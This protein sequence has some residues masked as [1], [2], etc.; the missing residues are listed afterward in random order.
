MEVSVNCVAILA[1]NMT[2]IKS[3]LRI[4]SCW[5]PVNMDEDEG[6]VAGGGAEPVHRGGQDIY[7]GS[8]G[9]STRTQW[10]KN[11]V[12]N[13]GTHPELPRGSVTV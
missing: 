5:Q 7:S 8:V 3:S 11:G 10:M 4:K 6:D 12:T 1:T 9:H 13:G 2:V